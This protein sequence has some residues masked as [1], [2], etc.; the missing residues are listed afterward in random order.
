MPP[1]A[2]A[3]GSVVATPENCPRPPV[4]WGY[5]VRDSSP[6]SP[7]DD[8]RAEMGGAEEHGI[9]HAKDGG[10]SA[11]TERQRRQSHQREARR[12]PKQTH[13]VAYIATNQVHGLS[14]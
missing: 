1:P 3:D 14:G 12:F 2:P 7:G 5:S 9:H 8:R 4:T 10:S 11:Q 6:K 13:A